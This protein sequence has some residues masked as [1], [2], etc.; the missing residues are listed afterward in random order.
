MGAK[1]IAEH[2]GI[3]PGA[4]RGQ[5]AVLTIRLKNPGNGF[6][7]TTVQPRPIH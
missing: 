3:S 5:L 2:A 6:P 4:M 1:E 7:R